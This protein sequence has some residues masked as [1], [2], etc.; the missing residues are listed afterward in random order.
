MSA[1]KTP[2]QSL[3]DMALWELVSRQVR[4]LHRKRHMHAYTAGIAEAPNAAMAPASAPAPV[5][6]VKPVIP[7]P[8]GKDLDHRTRQR[9]VQGK[10]PIDYRLD[11][12][13]MNA[14]DARSA[15]IGCVERAYACGWRCLLIITGKGG[16]RDGDGVLRQSL[17]IWLDDPV[18]SSRVLSYSPATPSDGGHGAFYVLIRRKR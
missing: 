1:R 2:D 6:A 14:L 3:P 5:L 7:N 16:R 10:M 15:V 9:F 11:L 13:G 12:H 8:P 17:P 18:I 4:P